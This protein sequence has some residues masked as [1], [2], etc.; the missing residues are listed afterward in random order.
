[1]TISKREGKKMYKG[2]NKQDKN[3]AH[4]IQNYPLTK[5]MHACMPYM[6]SEHLYMYVVL[7]L[8]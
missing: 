3:K 8:Y 1:M 2:R 4:N 6:L 5:P 7:M